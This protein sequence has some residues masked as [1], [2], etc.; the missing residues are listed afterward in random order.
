MASEIYQTDP[1][2]PTAIQEWGCYFLSLL[3]KLS[4]LFRPDIWNHGEIVRIYEQEEL[5]HDLGSDL[6]V[7]SAQGICTDVAGLGKVH[8]LGAAPSDQAT[9]GNQFSI[10]VYHRDGVD[11]NHFVLESP[12]YDPY[13]AEGSLSV[14]IGKVIGRRIFDIL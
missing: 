12:F 5:D 1:Q 14:K 4:L 13:S 9:G 3:K 2:F 6:T 8:Y 10:L 11:F 7:A